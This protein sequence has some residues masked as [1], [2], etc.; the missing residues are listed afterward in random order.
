VEPTGG[1][2]VDAEARV[3]ILQLI[4][5]LKVAGIYPESA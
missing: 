2:T 5:A 1:S 3:A 4:V